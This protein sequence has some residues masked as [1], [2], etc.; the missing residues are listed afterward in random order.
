MSSLVL[1][2]NVIA[3]LILA[4]PILAVGIETL[5]MATVAG[6]PNRREAARIASESATWGR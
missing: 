2:S 6:R 3:S 5:R 4:A 1:I